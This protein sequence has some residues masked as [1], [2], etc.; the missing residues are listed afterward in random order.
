V[1]GA[2]LFEVLGEGGAHLDVVDTRLATCTP[3]EGEQVRLVA[4][5]DLVVVGGLAKDSR[6]AMGSYG[7]LLNNIED[8]CV[9]SCVAIRVGKVVSIRIVGVEAGAYGEAKAA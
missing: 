6:A 7:H 3:L 9:A 8:A 4:R 2:L 1:R 5:R